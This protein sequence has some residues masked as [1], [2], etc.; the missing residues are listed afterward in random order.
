MKLQH[1]LNLMTIGDDTVED[2]NRAFYSPLSNPI[3]YNGI[4]IQSIEP[5]S[6]IYV[7]WHDTHR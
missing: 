7:L 4:S 2:L 6:P 5:I 3:I 1:H